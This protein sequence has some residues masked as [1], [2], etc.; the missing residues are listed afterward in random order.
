MISGLGCVACVVWMIVSVGIV[1][2]V[3]FG[4]SEALSLVP[5]FVKLEAG[6]T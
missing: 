3:V 6:A 2:S 5:K 1:E 4:L